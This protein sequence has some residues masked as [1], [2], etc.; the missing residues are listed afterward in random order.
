MNEKYDWYYSKQADEMEKELKSSL[1][2]KAK[3]VK[4][5]YGFNLEHKH[6]GKIRWW[7]AKINCED[8]SIKVIDKSL[9]NIL[10][11]FGDRHNF[12][13]IIKQYPEGIV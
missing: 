9:Y 6:F 10:K 5:S 11:D 12:E 13:T 8:K 1:D 2:G 4:I 7:T 3:I